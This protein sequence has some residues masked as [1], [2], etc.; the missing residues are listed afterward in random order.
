MRRTE[1]QSAPAPKSGRYRAHPGL[2]RSPPC[3]NPRPLRRAGDTRRRAGEGL[4]DRVSI[5]ARSEERAILGLAD[6]DDAYI[7]FQSAPAPKSGRYSIHRR[8]SVAATMFQSAP[9]P[10]SGRYQHGV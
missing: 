8:Q 10:K 1:F 4:V 6:G 7:V 9:A 3:F 5:R 2:E